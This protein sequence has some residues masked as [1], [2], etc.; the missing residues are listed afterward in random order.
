MV[1]MLHKDFVK[2]VV[3]TRVRGSCKAAAAR[4]ALERLE[5]TGT[6][7]SALSLSAPTD[8]YQAHITHIFL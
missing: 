6:V 8:S 7:F 2:L 4:N 3:A 1:V 5:T